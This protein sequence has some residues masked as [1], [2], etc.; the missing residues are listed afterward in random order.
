MVGYTNVGKS[1]I[2]NLLAKSDIFAENKLFATVDSTVRKVVVNHVP[3][4]LSDTVGF[5]RKLP[6]TLVECFKSTLD[7][8]REA[9]VLMHVVDISNPAHTDHIDVV[10]KT[11][12]DIGAADKPTILVYNKID[13]FSINDEDTIEGDIVSSEWFDKAHYS[14]DSDAIY[15]SATKKEN[16]EG[17]REKV[18]EKVLAKHKTIF[19]NYVL[20]DNF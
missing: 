13:Q 16:I 1:T 6:H 3:F 17:L 20:T 2:M 8:V 4:L 15:L 18:F 19:P 10:N 12:A 14:K 11:L 7:E 5:I 9:D